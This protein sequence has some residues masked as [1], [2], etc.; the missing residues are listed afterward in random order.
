MYFKFAEKYVSEHPEGS[1]F[2]MTDEIAGEFYSFLNQ[3]QFDYSSKAQDELNKLKKVIADKQYSEQSQKIADEL[4]AE[5]KSERYRDFDKSKPV[6]EMQLTK[7]ILRKYNRPE[8]E[9]TESGLKDD[10]QLQAA[11]SIIKDKD[12]Y[13]RF[14]KPN[15]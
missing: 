11:L 7:E 2:A 3:E 14:L 15:N 8:K 4:D 10:V 5:L 9:V 12:L 13:N 6:I 1:N